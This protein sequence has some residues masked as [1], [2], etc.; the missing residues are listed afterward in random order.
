LYNTYIPNFLFQIAAE[1]NLEIPLGR[2]P[3]SLAPHC[4]LHPH[5]HDSKRG[6]RQMARGC[7]IDVV[8]LSTVEICYK[9]AFYNVRAYS[10]EHLGSNLILIV[11]L[12]YYLLVFSFSIVILGKEMQGRS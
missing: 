3:P 1:S 6:N 5:L 12:Q 10:Y 4:L 2:Q 9:S 8:V 11:V 7:W